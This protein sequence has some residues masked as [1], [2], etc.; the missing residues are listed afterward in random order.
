M[1]N[2]I[3]SLRDRPELKEQAAA[4][5]HEKWGVPLKEYLDSMDACLN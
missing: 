2:E 3:I 5:F 4:W 1:D